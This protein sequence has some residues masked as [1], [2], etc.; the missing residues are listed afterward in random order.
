MLISLSSASNESDVQ[1]AVSIL[2]KVKLSARTG[3]LVRTAGEI[4]GGVVVLK[5]DCDTLQALD[6]CTRQ[7]SRIDLKK[8]AQRRGGASRNHAFDKEAGDRK[9]VSDSLDSLLPEQRPGHLAQSGKQQKISSSR[10][11][12]H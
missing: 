4:R 3:A 12:R 6:L 7:V 8:R 11:R 5:Y 10:L 9:P 1:R 2:H